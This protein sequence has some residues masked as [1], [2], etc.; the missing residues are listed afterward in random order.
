[1][2]RC[3]FHEDNR[4]SFAFHPPSGR[5][6]CQA[7][8]GEGSVFDFLT[9]R[10][11]RSFKEEMLA[12]GDELGVPRPGGGPEAETVYSYRDQSGKLLYQVVRKPGKKWAQ[13]QPDGSGGWTWNLRGVAP[14]PYHLPELME[15][16]DD[17]VYV[18]E[19]EKDADR[20]A[21]LGLLATTNSGGAG[22]WRA[23]YS[24]SLVDRDVV[25]L[26]DNDAPG[27][28]HAQKVVE[29]LRGK[30]ASIRIVSLP[31]LPPKGDV[32]DWLDQGGTREGLEALMAAT[33]PVDAAGDLLPGSGLPSIE[34]HDRPL[35]DI[36]GDAWAAVLAANDPP[37]V[38]RTA[39][40]LARLQ[41]LGQGPQIELMEERATTSLLARVA[42]WTKTTTNNCIHTKP[43]REAA[44][45]LLVNP[46]PTL[47]GLE[48]V[49]TTPVFDH[50]W[51]LITQ[52]GYHPEA[53]VWFH[54]A[55]GMS[56]VAVTHRPT[57][58]EVRNAL[59]LLLDDL[60]VDFPFAA[61]S[62]RAHALAAL[63][64]PFVRRMFSGPTPIHMIEAPTPGSGKSLLAELVTI[65]AL[66]HAGGATTLTSNEEENRKKLTALLSYGAPVIA[67]DN[68][69][70]GMWSA[71]VAAAIT[72]EIWKDRILG[73]TQMVA[74]PNRALWLMSAN[75]PKFSMEIARR[76]VRIRIDPGDER[77]WQRTGFKHDPIREWTQ[78][79]R[80]QLVHAILTLVQHWIISGA[81]LSSQTMGSFESW[82]RVV[83]GMIRHFG[84]PG[85]LGDMD[86]FYEA[87]DAE[88]GEWRAF[89]SAWWDAYRDAPRTASELLQLARDRDLVGFA[90]A[91]KN[92]RA[93][94]VRF[95]K[96]LGSIR[97][98]RFGAYRVIAAKDS[99]SKSQVFR[100]IAVEREA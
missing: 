40:G 10:S 3:P 85:F 72:A 4:P 56:P 45:D 57:D 36:F 55:A 100:L 48:A 60:L 33:E 86:E 76:C 46:H 15:R 90:Y 16:P 75:N 79:N 39:G 61:D 77:P 82:S 92:D 30:A 51:R 12:V 74:F 26:P 41:D 99:H 65:I 38:F 62:D 2:A 97:D 52:P 14:V 95:G 37:R 64:L 24:E 13:R 20:L 81:P 73:K 27:R 54:V 63:L 67:I 23:S 83:G 29:S 93:E 71:Q 6:K 17:P 84:V 1:M 34:T 42:D 44:G 59:S 19:G 94:R 7:G 32:S 66:G 11:G 22:K 96:S 8:C 28:A 18:V 98:R 35:R 78:Q 47:P 69:S 68:L 70:G 50:D 89:V 5:W 9:R 58:V 91:A 43:P 53:K 49:I 88:S 31:D 87:A 80:Q 25:I 21:G